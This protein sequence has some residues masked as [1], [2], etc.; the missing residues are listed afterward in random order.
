MKKANPGLLQRA[1]HSIIRLARN[2]THKA[3]ERSH[4]VEGIQ[5]RF[6]VASQ[7]AHEWYVEGE[8]GAANRADLAFWRSHLLES[9]QVVFDCGAFQGFTTLFLARCV[10]PQ[11][12]VVSFEI[13]PSNAELVE[14]NVELNGFDNVKVERYAVGSSAQPVQYLNRP[15]AAVVSSQA[16]WIAA[17]QTRFFGSRQAAQT[18]LDDYCETHDLWPTMVKIDVEGSELEVLR[19][20]RKLLESHPRLAIELHPQLLAR[21]QQ[22]VEAV[23]EQLPTDRYEHWVQWAENDAPVPYEGNPVESRV[24][25][26]A[27]PKS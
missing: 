9:G 8:G 25:L 23:L 27:L 2:N 10:G 4:E 18:T 17:L 20:A 26:F 16:N 11:G 1:V 14:R 3:Q 15:N 19:G 24:Q 22:S 21:R 5:F 12:R 7:E 13:N 6:L